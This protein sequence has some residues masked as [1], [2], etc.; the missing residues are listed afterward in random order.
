MINSRLQD[1][2]EDVNKDDTMVIKVIKRG[3]A[4]KLKEKD[5]SFVAIHNKNSLF[6]CIH[7]AKM[8]FSILI[9]FQRYYFFFLK[10]FLRL[11]IFI[12]K[13]RSIVTPK[14]FKLTFATIFNA[15]KRFL[16][17]ECR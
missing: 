9:F 5:T 2:N 4:F 12:K 10:I 13:W 6:Y 1:E 11:E 17:T 7:F 15:P 14:V 8:L 3:R 16:T